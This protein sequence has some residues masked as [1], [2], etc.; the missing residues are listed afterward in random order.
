MKLNST[1]LEALA[2]SRIKLILFVVLVAGFAFKPAMAENIK[3]IVSVQQ[4]KLKLAQ[5]SQQ[6]VDSLSDERKELYNSFKAVS[7]EL[8]ALIIY[9]KQ[10][11]KQ[12]VNQRAEM[13]RIRDTIENVQITERQIPPL[14]LRMVEGLQNFIALDMPFLQEERQERVNRLVESMDKANISKAEKFRAVIQAYQ[15]E[16]EYGNTIESYSDTL[17]IDGQERNVNI[18]RFG[19]IAMVYQ[20]PDGKHSGFWNKET[21]QWQPTSS[22]SDRSNIAKGLKIANKQSAPDLIILPVSAPEAAQ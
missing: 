16:N 19:R 6:R 15:R 10:L 3:S 13:K 5:K 4:G 21:S 20:T 14:V 7:K 11:T 18:L 8:E 12:I 2:G 22:G 9:N 17:E 1:Y